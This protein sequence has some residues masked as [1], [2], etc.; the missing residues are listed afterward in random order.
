M[1]PVTIGIVEFKYFI[2][3]KNMTRFVINV[4]LSSLRP[5]HFTPAYV[6]IVKVA[7]AEM[8]I[9]ECSDAETGS[10]GLKF[11]ATSRPWDAINAD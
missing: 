10:P 9:C 11:A 7:R 3:M 8:T 6:Y 4:T 1:I 5:G 2:V